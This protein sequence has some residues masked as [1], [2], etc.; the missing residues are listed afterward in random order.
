MRFGALAAGSLLFAALA[1]AEPRPIAVFIV[2]SQQP[3]RAALG[4]AAQRHAIRMDMA[5]AARESVRLRLFFPGWEQLDAQRAVDDTVIALRQD[6]RREA[7]AAIDGE[8]RALAAWLEGNGLRRVGRYGFANVVTAEVPGALLDTLRAMPG[9]LGVFP[10]PRLR[11][12]LA[13]SVAALGSTTFWTNGSTGVGE[14]AGV[15]DSGVDGS[16]PGFAGVNIVNRVFLTYGKNDDSDG[17]FADNLDSPDDLQGHGTHVAGI[18]AS[19][20]SAGWTSYQGVAKGLASLYNLK[21]AFLTGGPCPSG[22]ISDSRDV[23][24][25][26]D[27]ITGSTAVRVLNYSYGSNPQGASDD[28]FA[29]E[30][31]RAADLYG[32]TLIVAAGNEGP[33]A[34]TIASPA[35]AYNGIAVGNWAV[36]GAMSIGSSRGPTTNGRYKPDL[37][38]P[39]SSIYSANSRWETASHY[40]GASGTSM[41]APH[42]AGAAALLRSAGVTNPLAVKALL[43]NTTDDVGWAADRGWGYANLTR[44]W[45]QRH[46]AANALAAGQYRLYR[47]AATP[48]LKTTVVW[49]RHILFVL[50]GFNDIDL[51]VFSASTGASL[52]VSDSGVQNVEQ[53]SAAAPAG[54]IVKVDMFSGALAGGVA[55]EPYAI[56]FNEP[57][58]VLVNPP[59]LALSCSSPSN[60][61]PGQTVAVNCS[62][63]NTG[64]ATAFG[65]T[66]QVT[67]PAGITGG[68]TLAF[69]DVAS[70]GTIGPLAATV[71]GG[72]NGVYAISIAAASSSYQ[73]IFTAAATV[74]VTVATP[75][76]APPVNDNS[77]SATILGTVP[78]AVQRDVRGATVEP[79]DPV[80]SCTGLKDTATVWFHYTAAVTGPLEISTAGS[81]YNPI[82]SVYPDAAASLDNELACAPAGRDLTMAVVAGKLYRIQA[83]AAQGAVL[84]TLSLALSARSDLRRP[85]TFYRDEYRAFAGIG[86]AGTAP[87]SAGG[88][89]GSEPAADQTPAGD[90]IVMGRDLFGA[91]WSAVF[92]ST[93][94]WT[95]WRSGGGQFLGDPSVAWSA[96]SGKAWVAARDRWNAYWFNTFHPVTGFGVWLP[97]GGV[98][99]TDPV[100]VA[101]PSGAVYLV[102]KDSFQGVWYLQIPNNGIPGSWRFIGGIV[103]G[104][105]SA[106][107]GRDD[108]LYLAGR[109]TWDAVWI[110]RVEAGVSTDWYSAGGVFAGDP[111]IIATGGGMMGVVALDAGSS[112]WYRQRAEGRTT[113]WQ[114]WRPP[115]GLLATLA[116]S[117]SGV[118]LTFIGRDARSRL[119]WFTLAASQW[120]P[121]PLTASFAGPVT[122]TPR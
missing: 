4:R 63:T 88:V 77:A 114:P 81:T 109:D 71:T 82:V 87:I 30:L 76:P 69:G 53:V 7:V 86:I 111:G 9:V 116:T 65:V 100:I 113:G 64:G 61:A 120:T 33:P 122:A 59:N 97:L 84:G 21:V 1:Q 37:A 60:I 79:A 118:D 54:A 96:S 36:R 89:F 44:L 31:D 106:T 119:W 39:G 91:V 46:W 98:F 19:Q 43:I 14:S 26:I 10:A 93:G 72:S 57:G 29:R 40:R 52:G 28:G 47:T 90:S 42:I 103:K 78:L 24:D 12:Q 23:L 5:E 49:N 110:A 58:V 105:I 27:Y 102:G 50:P 20:G 108:A 80:H 8:Q 41:A 67:P 51:T 35:Y 70:G 17:C 94:G 16:H 99:S 112:V 48:S 115:G 107:A 22:A 73:E 121:A 2:L 74:P 11:P 66:G 18:V 83:S 75:P 85:M 25:A 15:L 95:P 45:G 56:A 117:S 38:A 34:N 68:G 62:V 3:H 6:A 32:L 101:T 55:S 104:K 13:Q 92:S